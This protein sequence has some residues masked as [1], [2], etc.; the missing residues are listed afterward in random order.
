MVDFPACPPIFGNTYIK[1]SRSY[2]GAKVCSAWTSWICILLGQSEVKSFQKHRT[3]WTSQT[4]SHPNFPVIELMKNRSPACNYNIL[5]QTI[6]QTKNK[7]SYQRKTQN[8][9]QPWKKLESTD[10]SF[11]LSLIGHRIFAT[12]NSPGNSE[13]KNQIHRCVFRNPRRWDP[14]FDIQQTKSVKVA[15]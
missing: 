14:S 15:E 8:K 12:R 13:T 3:N 1:D 7:K 9:T 5:D 10:R 4:A 11:S 6:Y 2:Q